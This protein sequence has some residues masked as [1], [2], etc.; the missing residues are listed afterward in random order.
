MTVREMPKIVLHIHLDGSV[1]INDALKW[2]KEDGMNLD[3]KDIIDKMQVDD[4]VTSLSDYLDKFALPCELLQTCCRL[5][6]ASYHL[7]KKLASMN[8]LYAEVRFAPNKHLDRH[9]NLD[10]VV[11]SVINGFNKANVEFGIMGGIILS[12]MRGDAYY[13]NRKVVDLAKKYLGKGVLGI[14]LAGDEANHPTKDYKNLFAYAKRLNVP[15][16]IHAGEADGS[17]SL[18]AAI[19]TGTNRIGHG[20]KSVAD[21]N[22]LKEI[23]DKEILLEIC[24]T[25]NYQTCAV[26]DK[27]PLE[28]IYKR[29][30][31]VNISTDNDTVSNIDINN[32][33]TKILNE[34]KLTI[35]DLQKCNRDSVEY[36]MA[37]ESIK[38]KLRKEFD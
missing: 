21:E 22:I 30:V 23:L 37:G 8:V 35:E 7:F 10:D 11:I 5:E 29:G 6:L 25:S 27:H 33:Y 12:M 18:S 2:A 14:D 38:N 32:E 9:L 24:V 15:Y 28:E 31:K 13:Q 26:K 4:N 36:I 34:T 19:E 17:E 20:I 16:T 3:K 1:E